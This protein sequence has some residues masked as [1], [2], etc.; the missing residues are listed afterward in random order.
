MYV[1]GEQLVRLRGW[2]I[3]AGSHPG[4]RTLVIMTDFQKKKRYLLPFLIRHLVTDSECVFW[5]VR[6]AGTAY[7]LVIGGAITRASS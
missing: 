6:I 3:Q 5:Q 4:M 2:I 7:I 1:S